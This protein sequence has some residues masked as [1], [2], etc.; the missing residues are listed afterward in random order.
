MNKL[1]PESMRSPSLL[2]V[3]FL[4]FISAAGAMK[5]M[6]LY[7]R[8]SWRYTNAVIIIIINNIQNVTDRGQH[9][10]SW[11]PERS[12]VGSRRRPA[13]TRSTATWCRSVA[14]PPRRRRSRR[15]SRP[16]LAR[17]SR[18][19]RRRRSRRP[20]GGTRGHRRE[21]DVDRV[22]TAAAAAAV[23]DDEDADEDRVLIS[24][25]D[26]TVGNSSST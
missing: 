11:R 1:L 6:T 19:R 2:V 23:T 12:M 8:T 7:L 15:R 4:A 14:R 17:S 3:V 21:G 18:R 25:R 22:P 24:H 5:M 26:Y 20:A 9:M 10:S 13:R 16:R